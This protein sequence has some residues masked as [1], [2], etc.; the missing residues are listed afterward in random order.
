MNFS[1]VFVDQLVFNICILELKQLV[2]VTLGAGVQM[3][4]WSDSLWLYLY[5]LLIFSGRVEAVQFASEQMDSTIIHPHLLSMLV[6]IEN[7]S[8][9]LLL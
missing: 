4:Y 5:E 1:N 3:I 7:E 6:E 2:V 9:F 8:C